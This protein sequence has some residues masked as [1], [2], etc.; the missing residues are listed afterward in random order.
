MVTVDLRRKLQAEKCPKHGDMCAHL[1]KLQT[2]REDLALMGASIVDEDFTSIILGSIPPSYNTYIA[3]ITATSTLLNQV[4]TPT[5]LIDAITDEADRKAILNPKSRKDE[6]D[7]AFVAGQLKKGGGNSGLKR[8]KKDSECFNCHKKGHFKRNCWVPGG[9]AEGKGLKN[10]KGKQKEMAAK[11][12]VKDDQDADAMWMAKAEVDVRSWLADFRDDK[13]ENWE[14]YESAGES[15]EKDWINDATDFYEYCAGPSN[16]ANRVNDSIPN[17][18]PISPYKTLSKVESEAS[19]IF[20]SDG[21]PFAELVTEYSDEDSDSPPDLISVSDSSGESSIDED[22]EVRGDDVEVTHVDDIIIDNG[23]E[24]EILTF[25]MAML[26]NA[27]TSSNHET[28]LYDSGA[29][30]HMSPY[31]NKFHNFV[32]IKPK[33]IQAADGQ[34]F[35]ATGLG[36]IHIKLPNGRSTL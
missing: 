29:S 6:H 4:L 26:A 23:G 21:H 14:E 27:E 30:R 13:F 36:D 28:E 32:S 12:E 1:N 19:R 7:A 15:W 33:T 18:T 8:L 25:P 35:E 16:H 2:M 17:L 20:E 9:G 11:T 34:E 5:N 3:A 22:G 24:I 31:C 10:W